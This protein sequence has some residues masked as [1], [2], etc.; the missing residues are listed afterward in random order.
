MKEK[1]RTETS[2]SYMKYLGSLLLFGSNGIVASR[3][4]LSS[5][6]IVYFRTMIGSL[7]LLVIYLAGKKKFTFWKYKKQFIYLVISSI[8]MG[9]SWL[10]LYEAYQQI[11]VGMA[12]LAYYCGPIIVMAL[13]PLVFKEK[14]TS[15][16]IMGF[17]SV[18]VGIV[19]VNGQV[20]LV[21]NSGWGLFCGGMSAVMYAVM[22]I[23]NKKAKD[24]NGFE[25]SLLQLVGSFLTVSVFVGCKQGLIVPMTASDWIPVLILGLL[26]TG[27]GCYLYFS[28]IGSLPV[29]TVAVCGYLEPLSAVV[30]SVIFLHERMSSLQMTGAI[31]IIG[32]AVFA[33]N[34]GKAS[35]CEVCVEK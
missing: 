16:K 8:T 6:E 9:A 13:S 15:V 18:L 26:N 28:S 27:I 29:Q 3:M 20:F 7:L 2:L 23:A 22:L 4:S 35:K 5:Y 12:S 25:N 34:I 17:L 19:L 32:G 21:G 14:L 33:E 24:I 31:L 1:M 30:F 10:F 11:G